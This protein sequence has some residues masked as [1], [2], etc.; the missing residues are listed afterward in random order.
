MP[1]FSVCEVHCC[2]CRAAMDWMKR[3]G[4]TGCCCCRECYREFQ[5]RETLSIMGKSYYPDPD[6]APKPAT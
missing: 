2:I 5:W 6:G 1:C 3:Y 4:R